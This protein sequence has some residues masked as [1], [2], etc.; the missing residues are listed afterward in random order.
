M[1]IDENL[2]DKTLE[3]KPQ[4]KIFLIEALGKKA[5]VCSDGILS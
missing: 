2:I 4:E 5:L 3:S 1:N